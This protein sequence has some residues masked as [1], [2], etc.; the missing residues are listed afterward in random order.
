MTMPESGGESKKPILWL[1]IGLIVIVALVGG[2]YFFLNQQNN[3]PR[4]VTTIQTPSPSPIDENLE[5][6]LSSIDVES[7]ADTEFATVDQ[8]LSQL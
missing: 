4:P 5:A 6:E 7:G 1:A 2:I 8:D 3:Q